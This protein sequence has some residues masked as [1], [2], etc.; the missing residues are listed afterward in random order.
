MSIDSYTIAFIGLGEAAFSIISGWGNLRNNQIKAYDIKLHTVETKEEILARANELGIRIKF[1][2]QE[3]VRDSD[4]IF[5]TVTADQAF[6]VARESC[7]F[8]KKG[9]YFFDLNSCAPSSKQNFLLFPT[10]NLSFLTNP[11]CSANLQLLSTYDL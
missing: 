5:S 1:S 4:L 3:L 8:I 7:Q 6:K 10:L 9:T 11:I 2:L